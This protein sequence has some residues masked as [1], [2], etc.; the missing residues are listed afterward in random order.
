MNW[1]TTLYNDK[2]LILESVSQTFLNL[3]NS[4][5]EEELIVEAAVQLRFAAHKNKDAFVCMNRSGP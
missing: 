2:V 3:K 4:Q 5:D 1:P